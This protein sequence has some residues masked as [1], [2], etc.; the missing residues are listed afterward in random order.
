MSEAIPLIV[1][2]YTRA[3]CGLCDEV[4]EHLTLLQKDFPHRLAEVDIDSDPSLQKSYFEQIPVVEVGPYTLKAPISR[5]QLA[6]TLGAARDRRGQLQQTGGTEYQGRLQK[7]HSAGRADGLYFWISKHYL[8]LLNTIIFLYVGL[9]FA[10]P[11][12]MKTNS[13]PVARVIYRIYSPLCHQ[14]GF[15]SFFL[16]GEQ[17]YYPTQEAGLVNLRTFEQVTS[18]AEVGDPYSMSRLDARRFTGDAAVGYKVALCERDV[19]IYGA[20]LLFGLVY[21]L[22]GR[23][24]PTLHW[25]LWLAFGLGP[26]AL[27]GGSQI[28]SQF[29]W[30]WLGQILPYRESTPMLRMLTGSLFGFETAWFAFPNIEESMR[31]TRRILIRKFAVIQAAP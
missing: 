18:Y 3:D 26:I 8:A 28:I 23:R 21:A 4:R 11:V 16:F 27:D 1:T 30:P 19:A 6:V 7:G 9:P 17:F 15:R 13:Q 14:F 12:L 20:M 5:Q 31:E 10:A 29:N 24:L 25:L 22:T 2:L